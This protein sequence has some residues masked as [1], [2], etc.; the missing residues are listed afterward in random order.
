MSST[1]VDASP[2]PLGQGGATERLRRSNLSAV[3]RLVHLDGPLSRAEL[4]RSTGL[5]RS[6]I[7]DLVSELVELGLVFEELPSGLSLPGRPS[8]VVHADPGLVAVAINPEVDAIH[9]GLVTLGG[10]VVSRVRLDVSHAPSPDEVVALGNAAV[11][12]L[13]SGRP[14]PVRVAGVG[15]AVPGQVRLSD[16][17]VREATHMG[18]TSEPLGAM[19]RE[20]MGFP[21]FAANAA[22]LGMR[23]ESA[24]GVARGVDDFV[25]FIGGPS[26]IGGGVHTGGQLL[27]G[28]AGYAGELGHSF[29][30]SNGTHCSCG[31]SGCLEAE[32]TQ[33]ALLEAVGLA[34]AEADR[35]GAAL[36]ASTDPAV[37]ALVAEQL[38]LLGI[39]VRTAVNTFNPSLVVLG[40]FLADLYSAVP[41]DGER[42]FHDAILSAREN[43]RVETAALGADQLMIG[44]GELAF[45]DLLADPAGFL[46]S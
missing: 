6:T 3:L 23:A 26:G 20:T 38:S 46:E 13:L 16:G 22:Y 12:G 21:T 27:A 4:T 30:R 45:A 39:A 17:E 7:G 15:I 41:D 5:N 9:V 33:A 1:V 32:V 8:P 42:L 37:A 11:A 10:E 14:T 25:Y 29:V 40:G 24:F 2:K 28:A 19:V 36:A 44:A 34:P 35:L 31:A 43:L 18:W